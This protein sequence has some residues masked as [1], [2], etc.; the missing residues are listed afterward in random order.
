MSDQFVQTDK[1]NDVPLNIENTDKTSNCPAPR[2][3]AF[4]REMQQWLTDNR[5][6]YEFYLLHSMM[7]DPLWRIAIL[8]V[9]V[10]P[11]DFRREEYSIVIG[12]LTT[13]SKIMGVIGHVLPNP[14]T[15][16]FLR[17]FVETASREEGSDDQTTKDALQLVK[18]LQDPSFESMHYCVAPYFEA[19]YGSQRAKKAARELQKVDVPNVPLQVSNIQQAL[20]AAAHA[21]RGEEG[22]PYL[23]F[24][25]GTTQER[26][27]RN[28]TGI[29]GSGSVPQRW[30]GRGRKLWDNARIS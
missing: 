8:S 15:V 29:D 25:N 5:E 19:W 20:A 23:N 3:G 7:H 4:T 16:E 10:T 27:A 28:S 2:I 22:D 1:N 11:D 6:D 12:A 24:V 17:T 26:K 21:A 30:L 18:E 13:A 14:P 9:P